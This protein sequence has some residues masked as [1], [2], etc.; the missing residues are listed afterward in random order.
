M[1]VKPAVIVFTSFVYVRGLIIDQGKT[2]WSPVGQLEPLSLMGPARDLNRQLLDPGQ[3]PQPDRKGEWRAAFPDDNWPQDKKTHVVVAH[4]NHELEWLTKF[5]CADVHIWV[6]RKCPIKNIPVPRVD[7]MTVRNIDNFGTEMYAYL[8]H[9]LTNYHRIGRLDPFNTWHAFVQDDIVENPHLIENITELKNVIVRDGHPH[10][11][12]YSTLNPV[13]RGAWV[14]SQLQ[15]ELNRHGPHEGKWAAFAQ[16]YLPEQYENV[17]TAARRQEAR[18][19]TAPWRGMFGI[20]TDM[21]FKHPVE[22]YQMLIEMLEDE[23]CYASDCYMEMQ[24]S[25]FFRCD[26]FLLQ[27]DAPT[28]FRTEDKCPDDCNVKTGIV[29][30]LCNGTFTHDAIELRASDHNF[31]PINNCT[32]HSCKGGGWYRCMQRVHENGMARVPAGKFHA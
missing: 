32:D 30:P 13:V 20:S 3:K 29:D 17:Q 15:A 9:I 12:T 10:H 24:T 23:H 1:I 7:C 22:A 21:L 26:E 27:T 8:F 2:Q 5:N 18:G 14:F 25:V 31:V 4:C 16:K 6:Y 19:W 28:C 11:V